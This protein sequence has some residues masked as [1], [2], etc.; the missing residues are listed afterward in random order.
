MD[1]RII[2]DLTASAEITLGTEQNTLVLPRSAVF[3]D[4]KG[5]FVFVRGAEGWVR[6][7]VDLGLS[8]FTAA[9][10]KSGLQKG[11][12]VALQRPL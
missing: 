5:R 8:S 10:V 2:P 4:D 9:S 6:K 7:P 11:D 12:V 1:S 3:N